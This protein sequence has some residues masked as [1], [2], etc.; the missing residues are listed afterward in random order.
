LT[1]L[2]ELTAT[3]PGLPCRTTDPAL[4][5]SDYDR[6]RR[7]AARL[8]RSCPLLLPC[9]SYAV[10]TGQVWGVW[11]GHDFTAVET[12]CG[13]E[14]G[15]QIHARN[16]ERPCEPCQQA[17]AALLA[18]RRR[19]RLEAEHA[20]GGTVRGYEIHRRMGEEA[21]AACLRAM[22]EKSAF[23]RRAGEQQGRRRARTGPGAPASAE[24]VNGAPAAVQ[25]LA[26]A[27]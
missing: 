2:A 26:L 12:H 17:H 6:D 7:H 16:R 3:T 14:R 10:E 24:A 18:G 15:H 21:C 27:G 23:Y 25:P 20:K 19:A 22:R 1:S 4:F 11:G 9:R 5:H 8:C 13:T